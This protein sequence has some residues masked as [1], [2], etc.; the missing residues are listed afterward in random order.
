M[1]PNVLDGKMGQELAKTLQ[2]NETVLAAT[3]TQGSALVATD[4][5]VIIIKSGAALGQLFG[6]GSTASYYYP[7]ITSVDIHRQV[8][9]GYVE[10]T[11]GGVAGAKKYATAKD[12]NSAS[13]TY[14][15]SKIGGLEAKTQQVVSVIREQMALAHAPRP[16][17][18]PAAPVAQVNQPALD[19]PEQI[20][21]LAS[22]R[23]AGI[24]SA[25]EFEAK[26]AELL[27]R[28]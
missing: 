19:I 4:Q 7:Q 16:A 15:Y 2:P 1:Q 18:A 25:D 14:V 20:Q 21:K 9:S 6:G 27:A 23:D 5:R 13:N 28:M 10:I 22:L 11:G 17:V 3:Q 24:L 8:M 12:L 26:K